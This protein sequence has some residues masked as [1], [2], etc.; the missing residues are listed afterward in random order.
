[1]SRHVVLVTLIATAMLSAAPV[2]AAFKDHIGLQLWSLRDYF[3]TDATAGLDQ[4]AKLGITTLET[5]GTANLTAEQFRAEL[6]RR[7]L[8]AVSAHVQYAA[9]QKD[10]AGVIRSVKA[11]GARFAICPTIPHQGGFDAAAVRRA[12]EDFN[13]WGAAFREAG[14]RFG[15]HP[16]GFEFVPGEQ[17]GRTRFDDLVAATDP[18]NVCFQLDVF[19]AYIAGQDPVELLGRYPGRWV[20]LHV[21]DIR[22]GVARAPGTS[23][24][25][26]EDNVAVG[27]GE[28]DWRAVIG[29]AEEVGVELYIIED[30]TPAPLENIPKSAKFLRELEL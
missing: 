3:M 6:D 29:K 4:T 2:S 28:I 9:M 11:L 10:V 21:K 15:Y 8:K 22:P 27:M 12:A 25:K 1:M 17:P 20:S 13:R 5:A 24:A 19:W 26:P 23:R 30:E 18:E 7:G 14:I 16:H